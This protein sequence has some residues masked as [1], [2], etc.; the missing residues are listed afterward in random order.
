MRMRRSSLCYIHTL[1]RGGRGRQPQPPTGWGE[2]REGGGGG[3]RNS[4]VRSVGTWGGEA[5]QP[6]LNVWCGVCV[7]RG[8]WCGVCEA[9]TL[10][11]SFL[12]SS[13]RLTW[14]TWLLSVHYHW[15]DQ[16]PTR[17]TFSLSRQMTCD[18]PSRKAVTHWLWWWYY[19]FFRIEPMTC[20]AVC[21]WGGHELDIHTHYLENVPTKNAPKLHLVLS[22]S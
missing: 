18:V 9:A 11:I 20:P 7:G 16:L 5:K 2:R 10:H 6:T 4:Q 15:K 12:S 21:L 14:L 17:S 13:S 8:W 19:W 3:R 1:H 22:F